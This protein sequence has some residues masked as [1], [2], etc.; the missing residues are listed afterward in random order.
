MILLVSCA[1]AAPLS[2][3]DL[4]RY[5]VL[6]QPEPIAAR[7]DV[8]VARADRR[9]LGLLLGN[10]EVELTADSDL[11]SVQ[12]RLAQP[13]SPT[14]EG[15][16]ARRAA[17]LEIAGAEQAAHRAEL[18]VAADARYA[19]IDAAAADRREALAD[20]ALVLA[21]RLRAA[22]EARAAQGDAADLDVR[23]GR[24][25]EA[26][27]LGAAME[28]RQAAADARRWLTGFH[29]DGLGAELGD[30][31]D[32]APAPV[33]P[34]PDAER[35][36]AERSDLAAAN[37]RADAA[38]ASLARE[39]A[40]TVDPVVVGAA[41]GV[42]DGVVGAGPY[43]AW[44]VPLFARNQGD[45]AR[46]RRAVDVTDAEAERFERL[47]AAERAT[48]DRVAVE[49]EADLG[50]L[51]DADADA[52][53]ALVAIERGVSSGAL[54]PST[55]VLLRGDVLAGWTAAIDVRS[56]T[57]RARVARLL[58]HDDPALLASAP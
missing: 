25:E 8:S 30:P 34:H 33:E 22:I 56:A 41:L 26:R 18:V 58:A 12:L 4:A 39:R 17:G 2:A 42:T 23:L 9:E 10:P 43:V 1:A 57:A 28:A 14:G 24:L 6:H 38:A 21:G 27:A 51:G 31:L 53:A 16:A 13:L 3:D 20:E 54:D 46:A 37:L 45:I 32:G 40:G 7:A 49:A 48:S 47:A 11:G 15:W 5:A 36:S 50:R 29:P 44:T 55:A 52:R 19:W 35:S